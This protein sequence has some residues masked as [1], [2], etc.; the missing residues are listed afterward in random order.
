MQAWLYWTNLLQFLNEGEGDGVQLATSQ[1]PGF[2]PVE[3]VM[4]GGVAWLPDV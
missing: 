1:L 3:P 2:D 4:M